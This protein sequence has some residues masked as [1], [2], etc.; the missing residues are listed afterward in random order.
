KGLLIHTWERTWEYIKKAGTVILAFSVILWAMMT[1]PS[2]SEKQIKSFELQYDN[3]TQSFLQ[4]PEI[5]PLLT[6][7]TQLV[8]FGRL[9]DLYR[10]ALEENDEDICAK[11][12][13]CSFFPL[14]KSV[15]VLD[16]ARNQTDKNESGHFKAARLYLNFKQEINEID[17]QMQLTALKKTIAG[18][19][20]LWLENLTRPL[21]F[22]Y[23]INIALVGGFAAKEIVVSTLGT[24]YSLSE[25]DSEKTAS[26]SARIKSDPNWNPLRAFTLIIFTML[27]VPCFVTVIS[28]R[29][30]SSWAWAGF[31]IIFNLS[32]AYLVAL[33]ISKA[34]A[35]F[36]I[37]L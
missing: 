7:E 27:Y 16:T 12:E 35:F 14:L 8:E 6:D 10:T 22:D 17:M 34:G 15:Y 36:G 2:L 9:Y 33:I 25:T 13:K 31:S 28:I 11:I 29:R 19:L 18:K 30:E 23:R 32:V 21:G 37:G 20:G 3:A 4:S 5:R 24:A 1:F 26:L